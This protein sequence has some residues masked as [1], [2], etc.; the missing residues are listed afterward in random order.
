M[1]SQNKI[2]AA[3]DILDTL[4]EDSPPDEVC[5]IAK[6]ASEQLR[7][8]SAPLHSRRYSLFLLSNAVVWDRN[9]PKMYEILQKSALFCLS[10]S[11]TLRRLTTALQVKQGL[12]RTT[13]AYLEMRIKKLEPREPLVNIA[14]DEVYT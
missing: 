5:Y 11:K 3:A 13:M 9:S 2:N 1:T 8:M 14:M 10:H 7:L 4:V 12:D 6:F